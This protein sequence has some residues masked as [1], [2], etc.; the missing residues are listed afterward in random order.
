VFRSVAG[1][2]GSVEP[3]CRVAL[4]A[5]ASLLIDRAH[6][7]GAAAFATA[8]ANGL[9]RTGDANSAVRGYLRSRLP[10]TTGSSWARTPA[11]P[12]G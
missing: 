10:A 12:F 7:G 3:A 11:A 2:L 6:P 5:D 4:L 9:T 8:D 1:E